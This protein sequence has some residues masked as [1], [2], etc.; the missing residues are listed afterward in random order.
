MAKDKNKYNR[1]LLRQIRK[2]LGRKATIPEEFEELFELISESYDHHDNDRYM[3]ERSIDLSSKE[4]IETNRDL[5][6]QKQELESILEEL[7]NTQEQLEE[8]ER[9]ASLS[10]KLSDANEELQTAYEDLQEAQTQLVHSEKMSSLGQ[11]TAGVAHEINNPVNFIY[12]GIQALQL[13]LKDLLDL[14]S[15]Y[16]AFYHTNDQNTK[17]KVSDE[18]RELQE[19]IELDELKDDIIQ[20]MNDIK[21]GAERTAEIVRG[22]RNFSRLDETSLQVADIHEGIDSTLVI[23][24]AQLKNG[25]QVNKKYCNDLM[26][27]QCYPGQLNQ[28]YMNILSNAVQAMDE[29][30]GE[31]T[32]TTSKTQ[33]SIRISFKDNG[34]GI[35][36]AKQQKIFDPFYT[37]KEIGKGTGLGLSIT[38]GI[39]EKHKGNISVKSKVGQ[40][41]EFIIT[42]PKILE[43]NAQF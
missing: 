40:G 16:Q 21:I 12:G 15:K 2:A 7:R 22:L 28:V 6:M 29:D 9:M 24:S 43:E 19:E 23:L 35:P 18:I 39:I 3:L 27:V 41:A 11:L 17:L 37:T 4:L 33:D 31:I 30:G 26:P 8:S 10:Q 13:S 32:I 34:P 20:M 38:Y 5:L 36:E 42:L 14:T 25:V 1:V